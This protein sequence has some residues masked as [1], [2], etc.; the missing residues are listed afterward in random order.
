MRGVIFKNDDLK[1]LNQNLTTHILS[2]TN[3]SDK[4]VQII[5]NRLNHL[6]EIQLSN[7]NISGKS[8]VML[9]KM[10]YL[11]TIDL[12]NNTIKNKH[13]SKWINRLNKKQKMLITSLDLSNTKISKNVLSKIANGLKHLEYLNIMNN[14]ITNNDSN[15][16]N[17][18]KYIKRKRW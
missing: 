15:R 16:L 14:G 7:T 2:D 6:E 1:N 5:V 4:G 12:S 17:K 11:S 10:N 13:V 18:L 8:L 9:S 3:I